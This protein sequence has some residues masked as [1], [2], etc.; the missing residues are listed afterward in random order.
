MNTVSC[1]V[2]AYNEEKGIGG[3][4]SALSGHPLISEI[5]VVDD[6][7]KDRT[8]EIARSFSGVKV[9]TMNPNG[10]KSRAFASGVK[11]A[12]G[13]YILMIDA[14][15]EKVD[16]SNITS[17]VQPVVNGT[18]DTTLTLRKNSLL[19][20]RLL[21]LDFVSGERVIPKSLIAD[22]LTAIE[23][24]PGFGLEVFL[25]NLILEHKLRIGSVWWEN[26]RNPRKRAKVGF[27]QGFLG[28]AAM[29]RQIL[30]VYPMNKIVSQIVLM[31]RALVTV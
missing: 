19:I 20:Y 25:N 21:N 18:V 4:L 13:E 23:N 16:A 3:V 30:R 17:L 26:V 22:H 9:I 31:R 15:L 14:D 29:I 10:G 12:S 11:A 6:G 27:I 24:L 8:A 5:I 7:S 28:D 1:V 2:C